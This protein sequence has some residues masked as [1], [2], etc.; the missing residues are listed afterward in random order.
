LHDAQSRGLTVVTRNLKVQGQDIEERYI[1]I[2]CQDISG[3]AALDLVGGELAG[4][5]SAGKTAP[6]EIVERS[7]SKWRRF[8][9]GLPKDLLSREEFLGLF[10]EVWFLTFWLSPKV[11]PAE[12]FDGGADR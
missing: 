8:W 12:S 7:L 10:G 6:C 9:S 1:D 5:L 4:A 11:G 2:E 3:H